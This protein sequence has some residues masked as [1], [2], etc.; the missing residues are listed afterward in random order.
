MYFVS[1]CLLLA[2]SIAFLCDLEIDTVLDD[3][4]VGVYFR[5]GQSTH[6]H[7]SPSSFVTLS[8]NHCRSFLA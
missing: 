1:R 2:T 4:V 7:W 6:Q 8:L 5:S 3:H